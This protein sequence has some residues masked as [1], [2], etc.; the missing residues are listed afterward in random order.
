MKPL[1]LELKQRIWALDGYSPSDEQ[2]AFH[3]GMSMIKL[4]AGGERGGKSYSTAEEMVPYLLTPSP[5]GSYHFHLIGANFEKPRYEFEYVLKSLQRVD[6]NCIIREEVSTPNM[7]KWRLGVRV[8]VNN[9]LVSTNTLET[10]SADD[11]MEIRGF[12]SDM[13]AICEAGQ[14]DF[15]TFLRVLGR[16]SSSSGI[17]LI[18]GTF[19]GSVGWYPQYWT[20]GQSPNELGLLSFSIPTWSNKAV[21]PGGRQDPKILMLERQ[22]PPDVFA[23]RVMAVPTPP[24]DRVHKLFDPKIHVVSDEMLSHLDPD[25]PLYLA[26]DPGRTYGYAVEVIQEQ[27]DDVYVIDEVYERDLLTK[28]VIAIARQRPW[29]KRVSEIGNVIDIAGTYRQINSPPEVETWREESGVNLHFEAKKVDIEEGIKKFDSYLMPH[30]VSHQ[31]KIYISH[32]CKGLIGELGGGPPKFDNGGVY[33]R[34][35]KVGTESYG[36]PIDANN[37]ASKAISYYLISHFGHSE[38]IRNRYGSPRKPLELAVSGYRYW[39]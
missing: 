25:A 27:N 24:S 11:P 38:V 28:E 2:L 1:P 20:M 34:N 21:F 15:D 9:Q 6:P 12:E 17:L 39:R 3:Q 14:V 5:R 37:H 26:I 4:A 23:E 7:G 8:M 33:R 13:A 29:W 10:I 35:L 16:L 19:E 32:R 18:S 31:P 30:P 22:Y 36:K